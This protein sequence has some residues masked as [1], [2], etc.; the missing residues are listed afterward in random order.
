MLQQRVQQHSSQPRAAHWAISSAETSIFSV[1]TSQL[2]LECAGMPW[3]IMKLATSCQLLARGLQPGQAVAGTCCSIFLSQQACCC[4]PKM[5]KK[6]VR[7]L[8]PTCLL[9]VGHSKHDCQWG[10]RTQAGRDGS[11]HLVCTPYWPPRLGPPILCS[12]VANPSHC[13]WNEKKWSCVYFIWK[14]GM[15]YIT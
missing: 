2:Q 15:C 13:F 8:L 5:P 12:S 14:V 9:G 4:D 7:H 1:E 6:C 11:A 3:T 10:G